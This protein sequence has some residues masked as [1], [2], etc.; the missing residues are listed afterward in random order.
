MKRLILVISLIIV[1]TG[2]FN[3]NELNDYA[4]ATG[5][6]IDKADDGYEVSMLISNSPKSSEKN[7][8]TVVYSGKGKTIYEAI[9]QIGL[10]SPKELYIGHLSILIISDEVAKEG[11]TSSIEFLLQEPRSKKN[12]YVALSK[13]NKAKDVLSITSP[14]TDFPSQNL[15]TNLKATTNLQGSVSAIDFNTL[16]YKL[17]NRGVDLTL[18]GFTI[19]GDIK[20]GVKE[21]NMETNKP[22]SY[23]KLT[24][25]AIFK[26]DKLITWSNKNESRGINIINDK[27]HEMYVRVKCDDGYIVVDTNTLETKKSVDKKGNVKLNTK[28]KAS[29]SEIT[30]DIDLAKPSNIKKIEKKV[31]NKLKDL[32][33]KAIKLSKKYSTDIFGIGLMYYQNYPHNYNKIKDYDKFYKNSKFKT[34][35]DIK[36]NTSGSIK[37]TLKNIERSN[38]EK[39]N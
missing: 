17:I 25:Q 6:A 7:Y 13:D 26:D 18:N 5:M 23:I 33:L 12:F 11:I 39:D 35:V 14:L 34:S 36:I 16:L 15:A 29:I 2:C 8:T 31:N 20:D 4:I 10:I 37:Q 9:K 38:Y 22:S 27:I 21:S 3:Y 1:C 24:N 32:E 19:V 30:C 28:G